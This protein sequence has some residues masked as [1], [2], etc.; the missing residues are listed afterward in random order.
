MRAE[1]ETADWA[2]CFRFAASPSLACPHVAGHAG[3][4]CP[5]DVPLAAFSRDGVAEVLALCEGAAHERDWLGVFRLE[6]GR[7]ASLRA[8]CC[9]AGWS[10]HA[11][12]GANVA[13][14][15]ANLVRYG[16][17]EPEARRAGLGW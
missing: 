3:A 8:R 14:A 11:D 5:W 2:E 17:T 9:G 13:R 10:C 4:P 7:F 6:D 16:L 15:L 1:L 12:G